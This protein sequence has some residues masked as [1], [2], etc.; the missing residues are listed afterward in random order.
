MSCAYECCLRQ[1]ED[2]AEPFPVNA[3]TS[4]TA[5]PSRAG[6]CFEDS[7]RLGSGRANPTPGQAN[8]EAKLCQTAK[9]AVAVI[10]R[11]KKRKSPRPSGVAL[12]GCILL[13]CLEAENKTKQKNPSDALSG[14]DAVFFF[15]FRTQPK[16]HC[17][18]T[19]SCRWR[20]FAGFFLK[21]FFF[22][23]VATNSDQM[24]WV[25]VA[26]ASRFG[27]TSANRRASAYRIL[28][29]TCNVGY[30]SRWWVVGYGM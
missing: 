4:V 21:T 30:R 6:F 25:R 20:I 24:K 12:Q 9:A 10:D 7:H 16:C 15:L 27:A 1:S 13:L 29:G 22:L 26:V 14:D 23:P 17:C 8:D 3:D 5:E 18:R 11:R 28:V 2:R 19:R